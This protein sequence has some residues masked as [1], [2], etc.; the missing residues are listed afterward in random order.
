MVRAVGFSVASSCSRAPLATDLMKRYGPVASRLPGGLSGWS[1]D[2]RQFFFHGE[3]VNV[4]PFLPA[5]VDSFSMGEVRDDVD[6]IMDYTYGRDCAM[7]EGE[8]HLFCC[9][10]LLLRQPI[11]QTLEAV[12]GM[13]DEMVVFL[14]RSVAG[15]SEFAA[16]NDSRLMELVV[17]LVRLLLLCGGTGVFPPDYSVAQFGGVHPLEFRGPFSCGPG[18]LFAMKVSRRLF[19]LGRSVRTLLRIAWEN[20][21]WLEPTLMEKLGLDCGRAHTLG[22]VWRAAVGSDTPLAVFMQNVIGPSYLADGP[23]GAGHITHEYIVTRWRPDVE[24]MPMVSETIAGSVLPFL[25]K[26][27]GRYSDF[28]SVDRQYQMFMH[29]LH[30]GFMHA[31]KYQGL[32]GSARFP[33]DLLSVF[34]IM[35]GRRVDG[36][37][38]LEF[39]LKGHRS[40]RLGGG[41]AL[42]LQ[43]NKRMMTR[44]LSPL[45]CV[46]VC[47]GNGAGGLSK[48][49]SV[50][51][52]SSAL[53]GDGEVDV[54]MASVSAEEE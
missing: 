10:V 53:G 48:G 9:E 32:R 1:D 27:C 37:R 6:A 4:D 25:L 28:G 2:R 11:A 46:A 38:P 47:V 19:S 49:D 24:Y 40:W 34:G 17:V 36:A 35:V 18:R 8:W 21:E 26:Q 33:T 52:P 12:V 14:V 3:T 15:G 43:Q 5:V 31:S 42:T 22:E 45:S 41:N 7:E 50:S 39:R 16:R 51:L 20:S 54:S 23:F 13:V 29:N 30:W 44:F